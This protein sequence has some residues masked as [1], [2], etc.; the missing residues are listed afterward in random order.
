MHV[1]KQNYIKYLD[2]TFK[3]GG[4]GF[5]KELD[6]WGL[7]VNLYR[8]EGVSVR[9]CVTPSS[10]VVIDIMM[11]K[12]LNEEWQLINNDEPGAI[13]HISVPKVFSHVGMSYGDGSFVHMWQGSNSVEL[14]NISDWQHR[15]KGYYRFAG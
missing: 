10:R 15:I 3:L 7:I 2:H 12:K 6:C 8:D 14:Q 9:D 1:K 13:V 11:Q 5:N 4:R